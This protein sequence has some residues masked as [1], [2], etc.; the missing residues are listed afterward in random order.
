MFTTP[1]KLAVSS[2]DCRAGLTA[3]LDSDSL[4]A[5]RQRQSKT[6]LNLHY[7][8]ELSGIYWSAL[9]P[10]CA[11]EAEPTRYTAVPTTYLEAGKSVSIPVA[12]TTRGYWYTVTTKRRNGNESCPSNLIYH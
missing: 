12:D 2:F 5:Y 11:A 7:I 1:S 9:W 6:W 3:V 8:M 10:T 4:V